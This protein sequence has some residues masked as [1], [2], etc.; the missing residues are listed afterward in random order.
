MATGKPKWAS[1]EVQGKSK[2]GIR[3]L[4]CGDEGAGKTYL[5]DGDAEG[6][7]LDLDDGAKF[8]NIPRIPAMDWDA[9]TL[10]QF[11]DAFIAEPVGNL[12]IDTLTSLVRILT[13]E[14]CRK[15]KVS[16]LRKVPWGGGQDALCDEIKKQLLNRLDQIV[17]KGHHV[18]MYGHSRY[19]VVKDPSLPEHEQAQARL[20]QKAQD[21]IAE[22]VDLWGNLSLEKSSDGDG[23][24]TK[25]QTRVM[26]VT[27]SADIKGKNRFGLKEPII[28]PSWPG[29][30]KLIG[31]K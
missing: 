18:I 16:E 15:E 3:A 5:A 26:H 4:I 13:E 6:R 14:V 31:A 22:W 1:F 12:H 24:V 30:F 17:R 7:L 23:G 25:T 8:Y 27:E 19:K 11:L 29:I 28:D 9:N 20:H 2:D 10:Y 21:L